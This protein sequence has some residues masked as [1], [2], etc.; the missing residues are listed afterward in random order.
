MGADGFLA[1]SEKDW[2]IPHEMTFEMLLCT[3]SADDG[4]DLAAYLSL[5]KVHGRFISVGLPE[6]EGWKVRPMALLANGCF[7]GAAH[8][9]SRKETLEMLQLAA[10]KGIRSWVERIPL[11]E[12]GVGEAREYSLSHS[13]TCLVQVDVTN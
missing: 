8:L 10:D 6:G 4:F 9:G 11:G 3:A 5:L 7:I 13:F 2:K 12:K 1:T